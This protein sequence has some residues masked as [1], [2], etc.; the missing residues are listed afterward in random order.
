MSNIASKRI[1]YA[2]KRKGSLLILTQAFFFA[3]MS[4]FVRLAGDAPL[5]QKMLMRNLIPAIFSAF[6][7]YKNQVRIVVPASARLP[8]SLRVVVGFIG[9]LCNYYAIGHLLLA[10]ANS[11][12][13]VGPF[14]AILFA[15]FFLKEKVTRTQWLCVMIAFIGCLFLILPKLGGLELAS[16]VGLIGGVAT[17]ATHTSLR[18][19][20]KNSN[21][22]TMSIVFIFTAIS[23][24]VFFVLMLS[25][26]R[27]AAPIQWVYMTCA[28]I[29]ATLAQVAMT[30][31]Y[32][33]GALKDLSMFDSSQIIFGGL[34]GLIIFQQMPTSLDFV[35]YALIILASVLLF[36]TGQN[37]GMGKV[38]K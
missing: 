30:A 38:T 11:L 10:S 32:C 14:F 16:I 17:G 28:G 27:P 21:M 31:A 13:K 20:R 26:Y 36:K 9:V 34:L 4:V 1:P 7:L 3:L 18:A 22:D 29:C 35:A 12:S 15:A 23:T 25:N 33:H 37:D 2:D 8:L 19:L 24:I 6:L 5:V